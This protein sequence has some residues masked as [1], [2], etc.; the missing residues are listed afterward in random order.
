MWGLLI[1]ALL[2]ELRIIGKMRSSQLEKK[3][4]NITKELLLEIGGWRAM[5]EGRAL[6]D[7]GKVRD[8]VYEPPMLY[9][10]VQTGTTTVNARLHLGY[11]LADVENRCSCRQAREY[12]TICSHVIALGLAEMARNGEKKEGT[13][14]NGLLKAKQEAEAIRVP[15]IHVIS[16]DE[17]SPSFKPLELNILLPM[18]FVEAW[19]SGELR[20]ICEGSVNG[21]GMKPLDVIPR[22]R[23]EPY[24]ASDA[25][26]RFLQLC[27]KLNGGGC[28]GMWMLSRR[29]Y[30]WFFE[31]LI[32]HSRVWLGKKT[33]IQ[34]TRARNKQK[35]HLDIT[36]SGDLK[37]HLEKLRKDDGE[38]LTCHGG[39]WRFRGD[40]LQLASGLKE[41]YH[42]LREKDVEIPRK[43]LAAFFQNEL[44]LLETQ[45]AVEL[46]ER[47]K[48]LEF[49]TLEPKIRISLDGLLSGLSCRIEAI[50]GDKVHALKGLPVENAGPGED[51]TPDP[52]NPQRYFVRDRAAEEVVQREVLAAGFEPGR[53]Q[54]EYY[55]LATESRVGFFLSNILPGWRK[56][57]EVDYSPRLDDFLDRCD[58]VEPELSIDSSGEDWLS[59]KIDYKEEGGKPILDAGEIARLLRTGQSH[60]RLDSGRIAL[61]PTQSVRQFEEVIRDCQVRQDSGR[62]NV[63]KRFSCYLEEAIR[64]TNWKVVGSSN[65]GV[66]GK[67]ENPEEVRITDAVQA[68]LRPYQRKGVYWLHRLASQGMCGILADEM[69]LG[70]TLQ[71]L[72]FLQTVKDLEGGNGG[73]APSLVI[74]PTS[75]VQNWKQEAKRYVPDLKALVLHGAKRKELFKEW[76]DHD[77]MITSYA[78]LRRDIAEY[79]K[80]HFKCIILDEAQNIKNRSSQNARSTKKLK[81]SYRL[82]LTGTPIE[83]SLL[84]L[85][86]IF[87]FLM[88]GYLGTAVDFRERYEM[89][90]AKQNDGQ[91]QTRLKQR[92]GPFILRRTK[93]Q[94]AKDL[95]ERLEHLTF[96]TLTYEQK[97]VYRM[98]LEQ[99]RREVFEYAGKKG[100]DGRSRIAVLTALTRL[101]QVSCHLG[102]LPSL[103][104]KEWTH[105]SSKLDYFLELLSQAIS[106]NHRILVFSQFVKLLKLLKETLKEKEIRYSYLDGSTTDRQEVVSEF[107]RNTAIPVFLISLKAGGTGMNLTGADTVIHFDPWWNPAVEEQATARAHRIGQSRIVTSYKLIAKGTVEE[108]IV[109]LQK[110]KK[111]LISNTL[112][113]EEAFVQSLSW[114]DLQALLE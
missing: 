5:K 28:P 66:L 7:G 95:P 37:L 17:A 91:A 76:V 111:D 61:L 21:Q 27:E 2:F 45:T 11:R 94:V 22:D 104:G 29:H 90:I 105:P 98:I 23:L 96:C 74:C 52:E 48:K 57:W 64:S 36:E 24:A 78:L 89:P 88:P 44:N 13:P 34:I 75:L 92:V 3:P 40:E 58:F 15:P 81:G 25:D 41:T 73:G 80:I 6:Y 102:L 59:L 54:P 1:I 99:S 87:D 53:I 65:W 108:K 35:L 82:V 19:K 72:T 71:T 70:K 112:V 101:R 30:G 46:S 55:T 26:I 86:S 18:Q 56:K 103:E 12:G 69:G 32:G 4:L 77:L 8:T 114:E 60:H 10:V 109:N 79:E 14:S 83:N 39:V 20:I 113:S 47:C 97:E 107:Q 33:H 106:G 63:N 110:K 84:D 50:Y 43:H 51:W 85:W 93:D 42:S 9:G 38:L 49:A 100:A 62:I 68:T 31:S 16:F 67:F